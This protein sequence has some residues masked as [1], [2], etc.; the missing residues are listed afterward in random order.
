MLTEESV[1]RVARH[2]DHGCGKARTVGAGR[3]RG[4]RSLATTAAAG[5]A[6]NNH[7]GSNNNGNNNNNSS[8]SSSGNNS[9]PQTGTVTRTRKTETDESVR[10]FCLRVCVCMCVCVC[11]CVC[12]LR[13]VWA[14]CA[15][16][17][18]AIAKPARPGARGAG[19]C[20]SATSATRRAR[21][22]R[23]ASVGGRISSRSKRRPALFSTSTPLGRSRSSST[24]FSPH[25]L[26]PLRRGFLGGGGGGAR[27]E[28]RNPDV[29]QKTE[30]TRQFRFFFY[31]VMASSSIELA[32]RTKEPSSVESRWLT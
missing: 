25:F 9:T 5:A 29:Q 27:C 32:L 4:T 8:S 17:R 15:G 23:L 3:H 16:P 31:R 22:N 30:R 14:G 10:F 28:R 20:A 18:F 11:V 26:S 1:D 13:Q 24:P 7:D 6:N 12:V 2:V 19:E 21:L